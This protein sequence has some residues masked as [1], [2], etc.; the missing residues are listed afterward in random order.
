MT[1]VAVPLAVMDLTTWWAPP[2]QA[3]RRSHG[4]GVFR[5]VRVKT[6][7]RQAGCMLTILHL[8]GILRLGIPDGGLG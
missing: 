5:F 2:S 8:S 1:S 7:G 3:G 4:Q 6:S